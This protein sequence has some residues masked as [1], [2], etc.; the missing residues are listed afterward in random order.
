M[1]G[2]LLSYLSFIKEQLIAIV[3]AASDTAFSP[4]VKNIANND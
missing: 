2:T 4:V 3:M 1:N